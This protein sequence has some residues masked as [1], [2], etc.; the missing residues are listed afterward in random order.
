MGS[1][2]EKKDLLNFYCLYE[3]I[4]GMIVYTAGPEEDIQAKIPNTHADETEHKI[5]RAHATL[6]KRLH[7]EG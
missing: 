3:G 5:K 1:Y 7:R 4:E 6:K 2:R